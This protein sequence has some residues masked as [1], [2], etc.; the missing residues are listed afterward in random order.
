MS[1]SGTDVIWLP[2]V[3]GFGF[4]GQ[5]LPGGDAG[6]STMFSNVV[7][8]PNDRM[9]WGSLKSTGILQAAF[10]RIDWA[11]KT[12][13]LSLPP[14]ADFAPDAGSIILNAELIHRASSQ[15]ASDQLG[16]F[17]SQVSMLEF[18]PNGRWDF[19]PS[20]P[21]TSSSY[22]HGL[23]AHGFKIT[24]AALDPIDGIGNT[25][26]TGSVLVQINR[27]PGFGANRV[28]NSFQVGSGGE[29]I[30]GATFT[31]GKSGIFGG[32]DGM[33]VTIYRCVE[34][35]GS[36]DAPDPALSPVGISSN[37]ILM[38]S[39]PVTPDERTFIWIGGG[40]AL[41]EGRYVA[42]LETVWGVFADRFAIVN[43]AP[44]S[45]APAGSQNSHACSISEGVTR[46]FPSS[47]VG[48]GFAI[49]TGYISSYDLPHTHA[50]DGSVLAGTVRDAAPVSPTTVWP[51][52]RAGP[53]AV[54][55][56]AFVTPGVEYS[57]DVTAL[58]QAYVDRPA[59]VSEILSPHPIGFALAYDIVDEDHER[60]SD[61]FYLKISW[62]P[63]PVCAEADQV[64][65]AGA[66]ASGLA[67]ARA[68]AGQ[69]VTGRAAVTGRKTATQR[70][71][72]AQVVAARGAATMAICPKD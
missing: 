61:T 6:F 70:A 13:D 62:E 31:I 28:G 44:A 49:G 32:I 7:I 48:P 24:D 72:A 40:L 67:S 10:C 18:D 59:Y 2:A 50:S 47:I 71:L 23:Q 12:G 8:A 11:D 54:A 68:V 58:V 38:A 22:M 41:S 5:P 35:D 45:R 60:E 39:I 20:L 43:L 53:L 57:L 56:P 4:G 66:L 9:S 52:V 33:R 51:T 34:D 65:V 69:A 1:A 55:T 64:V 63:A 25:P 30:F 17:D 16:L 19:Q 27:T 42:M 14:D 36:N 15:T 3:G 26:S 29:T 37:T 46:T 21:V